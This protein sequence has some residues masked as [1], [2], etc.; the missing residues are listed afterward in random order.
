MQNIERLIPKVKYIKK[1]QRKLKKKTLL[2]IIIK[3]DILNTKVFGGTLK[4]P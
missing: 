2:P 1:K 4:N 3:L